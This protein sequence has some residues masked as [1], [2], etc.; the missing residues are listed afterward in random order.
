MQTRYSKEGMKLFLVVE[1]YGEWI[2]SYE[3]NVLRFQRVSPFMSYEVREI[4]G[5]T[6]L[7]YQLGYRMALESILSKL[8][9]SLE[10]VKN[11]T[12][13]IVEAIRICGEY[14]LEPE[15]IV[16]DMDKVYIDVESGN[17]MFM[18]YPGGTG[19]KYEIKSMIAGLLQYMDRKN[20]E[21]VIYMMRFYNMITE[22]DCT[23]EKLAEFCSGQFRDKNIYE[24]DFCEKREDET[25]KD[26]VLT[27]SDTIENDKV[28]MKGRDNPKEEKRS[29]GDDKKSIIQKVIKILMAAAAVFDIVL[30]AGL[31]FDVLT[32]EKMGYLFVGMAALIGFTILY[33][34]FDDEETPDAIMDDYYKANPYNDESFLNVYN[35]RTELNG[36][37]LIRENDDK[38]MSEYEGLEA[39]STTGMSKKLD[40]RVSGKMTGETVLLMA[41]GDYSSLTAV[42]NVHGELYLEDMI[43]DRYAPIYIRE[44]SVVVGSLEG[45]CDY[46]LAAKGVSRFHAKLMKKSDGLFLLD[47]NSTNGTYLNG[48]QLELGKEYRLEAGDM[49]AF[50]GSGFFVAEDI[51]DSIGRKAC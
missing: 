43:K 7:Y 27:K 39:L 1:G 26:I 4:N 48:E 18:Y 28:D 33:M 30:L 36:E 13:S 34:V 41:D 31:I 50:A 20:E 24:E 35:E 29:L 21:C 17:L 14:L 11:M 12:A 5:E 32:Y 10:M 8:T 37:G 51:P 46:V 47:L 22:P 3:S 15:H 19:E 40:E 44:G 25:D 9:F 6:A 23:Y 49:I 38:K 2:D 42:D 45:S 16:F